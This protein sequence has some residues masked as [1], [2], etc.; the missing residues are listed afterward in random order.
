MEVYIGTGEGE[1]D[2]CTCVLEV[3][4]LEVCLHQAVWVSTQ[5]MWASVG[6]SS[7]WGRV[8]HRT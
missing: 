5:T 7:D 3:V 4:V 8:E 1:G 2:R 6:T